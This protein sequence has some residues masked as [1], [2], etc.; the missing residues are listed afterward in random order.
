MITLI[1]G[2]AIAVIGLILSSGGMCWAFDG[3]KASLLNQALEE[4]RITAQW[5]DAQAAATETVYRQLQAQ[6]E[7][8]SAEIKQERLR[9]NVTTLQQALQI[10][11]TR[12]DL[13]VLRQVHGYLVQLDDRLSYLRIAAG[14]LNVYRDQIRDDHLMLQAL[15]DLDSSGLLRQVGEAVDEYRRECSLPFLKAQTGVGHR[16]LETLW[17]GIVK[18]H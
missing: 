9:R 6:A 1:I 2:R 8:L 15:M 10:D 7:A 16:D 14:A 11:R 12:Y 3:D 17:N 5:V 18:G 4:I 13:L